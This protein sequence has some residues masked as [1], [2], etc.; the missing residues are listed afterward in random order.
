MTMLTGWV[1]KRW[2]SAGAANSAAGRAG[3]VRRETVATQTLPVGMTPG[4]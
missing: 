1:R 4:I 3:A 2:A